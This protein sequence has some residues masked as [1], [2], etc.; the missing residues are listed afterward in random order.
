LKQSRGSNPF[1][2]LE[3]KFHGITSSIDTVLR[4]MVCSNKIDKKEK[5]EGLIPQE[6]S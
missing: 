2:A 3:N 6:M 1:P 4:L 5:K